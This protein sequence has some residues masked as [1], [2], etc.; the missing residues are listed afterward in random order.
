[1]DGVY[2]PQ[3]SAAANVAGLIRAKHSGLCSGEPRGVAYPGVPSVDHVLAAIRL[4]ADDPLSEADSLRACE[5]IG[6]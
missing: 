2:D 4:D 6:D 1:M 3:A 5:I